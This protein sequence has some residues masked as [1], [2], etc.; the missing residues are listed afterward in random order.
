LLDYQWTANEL[1]TSLYPHLNQDNQDWDIKPPQGAA[2]TQRKIPLDRSAARL[3]RPA[4][5]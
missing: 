3:R 4:A 2:G 5:V 1:F